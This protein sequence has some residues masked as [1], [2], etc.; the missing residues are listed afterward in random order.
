MNDNNI[1]DMPYPALNESKFIGY[2]YS[3][4][5]NHSYNRWKM[6][7]SD[8]KHPYII[9]MSPAFSLNQN[10][11]VKYCEYPKKYNSVNI[12]SDIDNVALGQE[13]RAEVKALC[14]KFPIY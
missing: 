13:I 8:D 12:I 7:Y 2:E 5:I 10:S 6:K 14:E 11:I 1:L 3:N 9:N 4:K